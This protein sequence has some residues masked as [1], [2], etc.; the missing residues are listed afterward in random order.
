MNGIDPTR[1]SRILASLSKPAQ[2]NAN[3]SRTAQTGASTSSAPPRPGPKDPVVL[4][5]RLRSRLLALR[6][7]EED[8]TANAPVVTVQEILRWE[9]GEAVVAHSEFERVARKVAEALLA[10]EKVGSAVYRVI[11]TMLAGA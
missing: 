7:S 1:L 5:A 11:E 4:R 10:D 3:A 2:G 6:N 8:F 9:F